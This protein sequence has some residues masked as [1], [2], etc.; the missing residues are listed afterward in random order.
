M[1]VKKEFGF[2][3]NATES[4]FVANYKSEFLT[5]IYLLKRGGGMKSVKIQ[6]FF[7]RL[8]AQEHKISYIE[9]IENSSLKLVRNQNFYENLKTQREIF[10]ESF[11]IF[12]DVL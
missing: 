10:D 4:R 7:D 3:H 5:L 8:K 9:L 2:E 12:Y 1:R 6:S 11:S